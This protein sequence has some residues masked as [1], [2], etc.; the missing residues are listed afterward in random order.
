MGREHYQRKS[1]NT[2]SRNGTYKRGFT[3]KDVGK[4]QVKVPRDRNGAFHTK[5]IP[6]S[7]QMEEALVDDISLMFLTGISTRSLTLI[8][9]R[10]LGR[11]ISPVKVC[12][13]SI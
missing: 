13:I 5:A 10:L 6:K 12:R 11:S 4:V 3:L 7:Q 9:K 1:G 2:N 8:S